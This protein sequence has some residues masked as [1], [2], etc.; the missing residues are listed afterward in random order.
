MEEVWDYFPLSLDYKISNFGNVI[1]LKYGKI[2]KL[3]GSISKKGYKQYG[4]NGR[5]YGAHVLVA[6]TFLNHTPNGT[7]D[8]IVDHID[9]D[10]LNN[11]LTNLQLLS[12]H[13]NSIKNKKNKNQL[14]GTSKYRKKYTAYIYNSG[15]KIYLGYFNTQLEAH[16]ICKKYII[17]NNLKKII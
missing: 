6:M 16:E 11:K 2:K 7:N 14:F 17:D 8:L 4:V 3:K 1:S 15:K 5:T 12:N 10:K 13:K 9:D